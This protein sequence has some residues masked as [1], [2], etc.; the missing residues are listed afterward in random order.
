VSAANL[1]GKPLLSLSDLCKS[2]IVS[3]KPVRC[4]I[5][6]KKTDMRHFIR[7]QLFYWLAVICALYLYAVIKTLI[8]T[9]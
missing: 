7:V 3:S 6:K 5:P 1:K 8:Q 4:A 2:K 9:Y